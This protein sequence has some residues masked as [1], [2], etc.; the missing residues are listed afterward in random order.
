[1]KFRELIKHKQLIVLGLNSGTSADG[2]DLAA[3]KMDLSPTGPKIDCLY[4]RTVPYPNLLSMKIIDG[5]GDR[6]RSI[7]EMI[8]L[9]RRLGVFFGEE[10]LRTIRLLKRRGIRIDLIA[11]HGQTVRHLPGK[12][13]HR[14]KKLSATLQLGHPE[15]IACLTGLTTIADFRQTDIAMGGEGAPITTE[16]MHILFSD[17]KESRLLINIGGIANYFLFPSAR[18]HGMISARDCGPGNSLLDILARR[19]YGRTFDSGGKLAAKGKISRRLLTLLLSDKFL[20]GHFGVSTGRERFG[21]KFADK[22]LGFTGQLNLPRE[23]I[24]ATVT[25]LTAVSIAKGIARDISRYK[26][27]KIYLFGGGAKN[28]YLQTRLKMNLPQL[29]F[30]TVDKL[31]FNP[32]Y[33]EAVCYAVMGG[34]VIHGTRADLSRLTG[35][36]GRTVAGRIVLPAG[37]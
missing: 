2:L 15:S 27:D 23:D 13:I 30:I 3:V 7:D 12:F 11:S 31:G 5:I 32:D 25:E 16:A 9:D 19:L 29:Q 6:F 1:M 17:K 21:E 36:A 28:K 10:A 8:L 35:V 33:L 37:R 22:T 26:I 20:K 14:G 34:L 18:N 24:L 4:G